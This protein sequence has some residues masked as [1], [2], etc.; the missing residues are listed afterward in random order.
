MTRG[1]NINSGGRPETF[2]ILETDRQNCHRNSLFIYYESLLAKMCIVFVCRVLLQK[3]YKR[4]LYTISD[5][6]L[7]LLFPSH[8][9]NV[10]C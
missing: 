8:F 3:L 4:I 1:S 7:L 10:Q 5:F 9:P 6:L 2:L